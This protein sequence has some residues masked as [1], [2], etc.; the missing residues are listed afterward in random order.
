MSIRPFE[1]PSENRIGS[2]APTPGMPFGTQRKLVFPFGVSFPLLVVVAET[3]SGRTVRDMDMDVDAAGSTNR[4]GVH[5]LASPGQI[6]RKRRDPPV[7]D[8]DVGLEDVRH[9]GDG[10]PLIIVS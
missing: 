10:P 4:S 1:T 3:G 7:P 5:D 9:G 6:G 2:R 8:A